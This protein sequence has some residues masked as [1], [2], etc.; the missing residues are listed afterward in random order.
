M[1]HPIAD[2]QAS[3]VAALGADTQL[4]AAIGADAV[5]D[6]PPKGKRAPYLVILRHDLVTRDTDI[7]PGHDHRVQI[8]AWHADPSRAAVLVLA[9]R[10]I[11]VMESTDLS[12]STLSV[13]HIQ[14]D[15]TETAIDRK[16]GQARALLVF[17]IFSE[18]AA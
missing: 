10:V 17:R 7:L 4:V 5:F 3:I 13:S 15:R 14:L 1:V 8:Q 12:S 9:E 2:L 6:M 18:P 11:T 16:S